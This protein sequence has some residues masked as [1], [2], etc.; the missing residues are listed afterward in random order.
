MRRVDYIFH[1][2]GLTV[3]DQTVMKR[4][5]RYGRLRTSPS[6]HYPVTARITAD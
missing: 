1:T 5:Y 2:S 3:T 4:F 6:T